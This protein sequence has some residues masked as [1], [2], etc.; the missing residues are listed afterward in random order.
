MH[1]VAADITCKRKLLLAAGGETTAIEIQRRLLHL[2]ERN[3]GVLPSW[4]DAICALWRRTLDRLEDAP[5]SLATVLDWAIKLRLFRERAARYG[6]AWER[7]PL[8]EFRRPAPERGACECRY[9]GPP[10]ER[11]AGSRLSHSR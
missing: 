5:D 3:R 2:A 6:L 8:L 10:V 11:A 1:T 7:F 9:Q 4:A